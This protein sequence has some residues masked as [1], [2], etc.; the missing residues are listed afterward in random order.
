MRRIGVLLALTL[1]PSATEAAGR[2]KTGEEV[3]R[4][5]E[6]CDGDRYPDCSREEQVTFWQAFGY[7]VGVLDLLS[8]SPDLQ[9][10][11]PDQGVTKGQ[12]KDVVMKYLRDHPQ[13]RHETAARLVAGAIAEA[14]PCE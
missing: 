12:V 8:S 7:I 10:C 13:Y 4:E 9:R 14:W 3:Y 5:I 1:L 11:L 2:F 6:P